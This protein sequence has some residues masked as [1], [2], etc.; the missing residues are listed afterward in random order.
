MRFAIAGLLL[1]M[2]L[3]AANARNYKKECKDH[4]VSQYKFCL[5]R[6]TTK[7]ARKACKA[8]RKVCKSHCGN[9][10]TPG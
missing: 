5:N 4:C 6:S 1:A 2:T 7:G 10:K 3:P 9:I 8:E